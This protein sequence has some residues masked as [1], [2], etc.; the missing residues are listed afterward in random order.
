MC[1][2]MHHTDLLTDGKNN[3]MVLCIF[4]AGSKAP[5]LCSYR[6]WYLNHGHQII[7]D[8]LA[9]Q[10]CYTNHCKFITDVL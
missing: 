7:L 9:N 6:Y 10:R 3:V 5:N 2:N 8:A 1:V 4:G